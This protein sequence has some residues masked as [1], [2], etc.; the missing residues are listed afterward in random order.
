MTRCWYHAADCHGPCEQHHPTR[1][2]PGRDFRFSLATKD[3]EF[4]PVEP[5]ASLPPPRR[6]PAE[7]SQC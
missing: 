6:L 2:P 4:E 7:E 3:G 5:L 1:Q